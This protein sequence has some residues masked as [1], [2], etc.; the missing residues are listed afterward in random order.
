MDFL[1]TSKL[2]LAK[3][4]YE[5]EK[6]TVVIAFWQILCHEG[7]QEMYASLPLTFSLVGSEEVLVYLRFWEELWVPPVPSGGILD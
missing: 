4:G 7:L 1:N 5:I 6:E 3:N 2:K